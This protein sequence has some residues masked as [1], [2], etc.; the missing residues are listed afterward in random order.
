MLLSRGGAENIMIAQELFTGYN[1]KKFPPS[2]DS[3]DWKFLEATLR[4]F[5]FPARFKAWIMECVSTVIF[6]I[7]LNGSTHGFF[8][9][10]RG[11]QQGDPLSPYLF[12][13]VMEM[14]NLMIRIRIQQCGLFSYHWRCKDLELVMLSFADDL[15]LFSKAD[16]N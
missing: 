4:V 13:L 1:R 3:V 16:T 2:F 6:S 8:K 14:L 5:N 10:A 15:L 7:S 9:G 11:L 12:V